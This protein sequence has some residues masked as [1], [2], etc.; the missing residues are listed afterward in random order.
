MK[1]L[2]V[3]ISLLLVAAPG[4]TTKAKARAQAQ[5]AFQAGQTQALQNA[6]P[7]TPSLPGQ[8]SQAQAPPQPSVTILGQVRN[9]FV[10]WHENLTLA[11]AI[12]AAVYTGFSDPRVIRLVRGE[13]F[14]DV[15]TRDL[16]RGTVNPT[17]EPGDVIEL[18]R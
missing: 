11:E 12:D 2:L 9:R 3:L 13:E 7:P 5:R 1:A 14:L 4:C 18:R 6:P 17:V 10:P 16:L 8:P 15:A